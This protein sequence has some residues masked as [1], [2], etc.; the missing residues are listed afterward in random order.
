MEKY[1]IFYLAGGALFLAV[2]AAGGAWWEFVVGKAPNPVLYIG[3]SPFELKAELLGSQLLKP[4]P[5]ILAL[6][7][8]ERLLALLGSATI[9]AGSLLPE[10]P[11]TRKLFNLRPL[12][13]PLG[14][15]AL[16][17]AGI[18]AV[19]SI[20]HSIPLLAQ[21]LPN[22]RE[23]LIPYSS[24]D[25]VVNLYPL[26]RVEGS[27]KVSTTSQ[28]TTQFWLALLSGALCLAGTTTYRARQAT[29]RTSEKPQTGSPN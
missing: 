2:T 8:A 3:L 6:F 15:A 13:M 23:A 7:T 28:F 16:T 20:A 21:T 25:L 27:L 24:Q 14:F 19:T 9:I 1:R 22:L 11:W 17:L 29:T 26:A 4:S 10:K 5:F 18:A 12:T